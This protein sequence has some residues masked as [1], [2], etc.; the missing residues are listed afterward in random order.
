MCQECVYVSVFLFVSSE[1]LPIYQYFGC[2]FIVE[3]EAPKYRL[4]ALCI[5]QAQTG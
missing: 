1:A 3:S 4:G 5:N 2:P